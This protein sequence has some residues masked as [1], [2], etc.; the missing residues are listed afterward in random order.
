ML[1]NGTTLKFIA[2]MSE[3]M[4]D[5]TLVGNFKFNIGKCATNY[6]LFTIVQSAAKD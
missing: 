4:K 5:V 3:D 1:L 2:P 6:K